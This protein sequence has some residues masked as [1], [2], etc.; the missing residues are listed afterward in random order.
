MNN[1]FIHQTKQIN[2]L[3]DSMIK[4]A[5]EGTGR[6]DSTSLL[7]LYSVILD[8]AH[9]IKRTMENEVQPKRIWEV[10]GNDK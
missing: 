6:S 2:D 9:K 10:S 5:I 1:D 8:C 4:M 7:L 3:T